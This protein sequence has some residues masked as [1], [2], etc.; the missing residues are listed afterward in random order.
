MDEVLIKDA[1]A[2][3]ETRRLQRRELFRVAGFAG[4]GVS[5]LALGACGGGGNTTPP[6]QG[7]TAS[8]S[9]I[10]SGYPASDGDVLNFALNL[11]YLEA[12]FY[13]FAANGTAI[14]SSMT[15]GAG[16]VGAAMGGRAV[17]FTS[18][19]VKAIAS[20]IAQD[21]LN[22]VNFLRTQLGSAAVGQPAVDLSVSPTSAFSTAAQAAGLVPAG[23]AFDPYASDENFLLAAYLFEDV[24]VTAYIGGSTLISNKTYLEAAAG[25]LAT[26]AYHASIVRTTFY[27]LGV[28]GPSLGVSSVPIDPFASTAAISS[29]RAK[30]DG[31]GNDDIGIGSATAPTVVDANQSTAIV[32]ARTTGQVLN[33]VYLNSGAVSSGGFFPAGLNGNVV[34]SG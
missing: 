11:E 25:I 7:S 34:T 21:E 5:A 9:P 20:E 12:N 32:P 3:Q 2:K 4:V 1:L 29:A 13:S 24:G 6:T 10:T 23:T 26:E 18:P 28:N 15:S 16:V 14:P 19:I 22:H 31:T 33:I 8:T 27:A 17:S 30:L